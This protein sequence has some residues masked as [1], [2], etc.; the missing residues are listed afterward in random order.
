MKTRFIL[1]IFCACSFW[2]FAQYNSAW[3]PILEDLAVKPKAN[4]PESEPNLKEFALGPLQKILDGYVVKD[5]A[6][7][8]KGNAWIATLKQGLIRYNENETVFYNSENSVLP[9]NFIIWDIAVDKDDN[10]WIGADGLWKYD[11]KEF[12]HYNSQNTAIPEDAVWSIA[13]DSKNNIW[14]ASCRFRQGGLVKYDGKSWTIYTPDNSPLPTNAV[15]SITIDQSDNIWLS[16]SDY[17]NQAYLVKISNDEWN[18]YDKNDFGFSPYY[19]GG[20]QCD[21][22]NRLWVTIDYSL[23]ATVASPPPH[24]FIFDG[25]H[26]SQLS[27]RQNMG[28]GDRR[29][30]LIIDHNDYVW[31]FGVGAIC[32]VWINEQ[33]TQFDDSE[34]EGE[35]IW[36]IKEDPNHRLWFGMENG[37]YVQSIK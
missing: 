27:C 16:L 33:W 22:K 24:F 26:T 29:T 19:L 12:T 35:R 2:A 13:V 30:G 20:I 37:I 10:V 31:C 3:I 8:S 7:D 14:F 9:E 18:I 28:F 4:K 6:F 32:G 36:V 15:K 17:V 11:G 21:G 23:A 25:K 34:F 5:I 1:I